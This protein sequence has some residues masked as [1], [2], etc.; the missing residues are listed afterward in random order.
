MPHNERGQ[1]SFRNRSVSQSHFAMVPR[2]DVPRSVFS[3]D[4]THK[5]AFNATGLIPVYLEEV[6]PGDT[7]RVSMTAFCRMA[8]PVFPVMDNLH[9]ESF[10]FFVPNRL[11]W[12]NWAKMMGER[13][14]PGDTVDYVVPQVSLGAP[15]AVGSVYDYMGVPTL[16][17]VA[18]I[19]IA[20]NALPI[21]G[22]RLIY[23]EWFRDQNLVNPEVVDIDDGPDTYADGIFNPLRRGKRHDYFT[24]CLPWPQKG[25]AVSIPLTGTAPVLGIGVEGATAT[26]GPIAAW[27][28]SGAT[29]FPDFSRAGSGTWSPVGRE[30]LIQHDP[31][32]G[33]PNIYADLS[34]ATSATINALRQA[35]QVQKLLERD[36]RGGTRYTE[37]LLSH[38]GVQPQDA[39]LQ[40]PEYLGGGSTMININPIAQTSATEEGNTP[41][42]SLGGVGT[43]VAR[44][45]FSLSATE[46]G[47]VIGLVNVRVDHTYQQGLRRHWSR[48]TRYDYYWPAFAHLGEQAVLRKEIYYV[49]D[50][51]L[52]ELVFGYQERWAEYRYHPSE[53]S[54]I[55]RSTAANNIDEWHFAMQFTA[56]PTLS[57]AF[58]LETWPGDR[59]LAAGSA[60]GTPNPQ[61]FLF[62]GLFSAKITR[63]MPTYSVPG[64]I[65]RF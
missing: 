17:Q 55:F 30:F 15:P 27:D 34:E 5:T 36:A 12:E 8:T 32:T 23:N 48:N 29:S 25:D 54:G 45:G 26:A 51:T 63:A 13:P 42:G 50:P 58:I 11:V 56:P 9:L 3:V 37:L 38:F 20:F 64:F 62:D 41:I 2:A 4:H 43:A 18:G 31:L 40:R 61:Q 14:S 1:V 44:H 16:G 28:S 47:F 19:G 49:N 57:S 22:Y 65:D 46:H 7:F 39:R 35:F 21:R 59:I 6:L 33:F 24:S 53:I 52:D 60:A 10:F